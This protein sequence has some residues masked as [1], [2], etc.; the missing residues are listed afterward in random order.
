MSNYLSLLVAVAVFSGCGGVNSELDTSTLVR[1]Q[2]RPNCEFKVNNNCYTRFMER[3]LHCVGGDAPIIGEF[4]DQNRLCTSNNTTVVFND[5]LKNFDPIGGGNL[6]FSIFRESTQFCFEVRG[7]QT[8]YEIVD[9]RGDIVSVQQLPDGQL[10][11]ECADQQVLNFSKQV[12]EKGCRGQKGTS[13][14]FLPGLSWQNR[15]AG[16]FL[17]IQVLGLGRPK[18]LMNCYY[19]MDQHLV[20]QPSPSQRQ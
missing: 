7:S 2:K 3:A 20:V 17:D 10:K 19:S 11:V 4:S 9:N 12:I 18:P 13:L 15:E 16:L 6:H 8:Q 5:F 1:L 14:E